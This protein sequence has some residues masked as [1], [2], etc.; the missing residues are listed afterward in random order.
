MKKILCGLLA[1]V[2]VAGCS[3]KP[4]ETTPTPEATIAPE[5]TVTP[6]ATQQTTV[7]VPAEAT[8]V[9]CSQEG[10]GIS[11]NTVYTIE[12]GAIIKVDQISN[13]TASG[14][15]ML[16][17]ME[18]SL[19]NQK[20]AFEGVEGIAFDYT[21]G[22]GTATITSS[23]DITVMDEQSLATIGLTADLK[24]DKGFMIQPIVDQYGSIGIACTIK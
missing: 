11:T 9:D 13:F 20:A 3:T 21:I 22:D 5:T 1:L 19:V 6:E 18:E 2:L 12:N 15:E 4:A 7:T 23:Y 16:K 14:D 10:E 8:T 24:T 17:Q